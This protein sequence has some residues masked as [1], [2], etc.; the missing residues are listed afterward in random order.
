M[1]SVGNNLISQADA[2]KKVKIDYLFHSLR[3]PKPDI[4]KKIVQLR[5]IRNL[6]PKQYAMLKRQLPYVV[7]AA[8]KPP[9]RRTENFAYTEYF[10]LDID[11]LYE[12]GLDLQQVRQKL[13]A[14]TRVMLCFLSPS[15]DGLKVLFHLKER[16][17]D[18]GLY[19]LFYKVFLRDFSMQHG[20]EQAID[21]RTS[22]VCR[23]CF[24]S[25]D[26]KAYYNPQAEPV[27]LDSYL[28]RDD[29]Y[30][31]FEMKSS[32][33]KEMKEAEE[34][35]D[36]NERI[37]DPGA[38]VIDRVKALL[39]P[40]AIAREK[41]EP[42]VPQQLN[43]IMDDLKAYVEETGVQLYEIINI[44]YGKKMRFRAG[45]KLA[46]INLFYGKNG[47]SVVQSPRCGTSV[48]FN[49]LMSQ[50]VNSFIYTLVGYG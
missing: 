50:L 22:D 43:E 30:S 39:N 27:D 26:E 9:Y 4:K 33:V 12:K 46:E 47:F 17:Y 10:I 24:V 15:E 5:I 48:E 37:I 11:H 8:F 29:V 1:L 25:I 3:N 41:F 6:D 32:L 28:Q 34:K 31:L 45:M 20:L 36:K 13:Q 14:D 19:S 21:E 42:Y 44:Q 23:A 7:C 40:K 2:L 16:C 35:E 38:D 49:E 18:A